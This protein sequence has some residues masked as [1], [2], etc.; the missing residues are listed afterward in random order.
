MRKKSSLK[1]SEI[2]AFAVI[3]LRYMA[4]ASSLWSFVVFFLPCIQGLCGGDHPYHLKIQVFY[5]F[6]GPRDESISELDIM[7]F[8]V[9]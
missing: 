6:K 7:L 3:R 2:K 4:P 9:L 1:L 8:Q 5:P